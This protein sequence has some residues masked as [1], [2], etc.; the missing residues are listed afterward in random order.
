MLFGM[1][2]HYNPPCILQ[3]IDCQRI[4]ISSKTGYILNERAFHF[5][6]TSIAT[7]IV[8]VF[9]KSG[10]LLPYLQLYETTPLIL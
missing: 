9:Q 3:H 6:Y 7:T 5:K 2:S 1:A 4:V 8:N 10:F